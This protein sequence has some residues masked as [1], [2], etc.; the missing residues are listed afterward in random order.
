MQLTVNF[1]QK[2]SQ[3]FVLTTEPPLT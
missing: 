2:I 1:D 3:K